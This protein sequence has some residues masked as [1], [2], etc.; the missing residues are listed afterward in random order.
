MPSQPWWLAPFG[1]PVA[2][3]QGDHDA[4]HCVLQIRVGPQSS[5]RREIRMPGV[6]WN[7]RIVRHRFASS[8][9]RNSPSTTRVRRGEPWLRRDDQSP[10]HW[11]T[12]RME[13]SPQRPFRHG[14][15]ASPRRYHAAR[16]SSAEHLARL[17]S[18]WLLLPT[19]LRRRVE[20]RPGCCC[21]K[22][23][24]VK[25]PFVRTEADGP[26]TNRDTAALKAPLCTCGTPDGEVEARL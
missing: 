2:V 26:A 14:G 10:R 17:C 11:T 12:R 8:R 6:N 20:T 16:P 15:K 4:T 1:T 13:S 19:L 7:S 5:P 18:S 25:V 22:L 3:G 21:L 9:C 24:S 23:T